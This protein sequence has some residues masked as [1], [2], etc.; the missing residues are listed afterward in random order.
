MN[1]PSPELTQ[2]IVANAQ[3]LLSQRFGGTQQLLE[4]KDLA[5][6][7]NAVV[8]R[9]KVAPSPFLQHKSVVLKYVPSA[10][11]VA[12]KASLIREIVAYQFTTSLNEEVRPGPV[13]LAYDV[14]KKLLVIT[15]AGDGDTVAD[16]LTTKEDSTRLSLLRNLGR[17]LGKMHSGTASK[18]QDFHILLGRM[19]A[20]H[21]NI[22]R[23]HEYRERMI[24]LAI[25][26]GQRLVA[27]AGITI[28]D[29]VHN[30]ATDASR[31]LV[32]GQHRAF[33]P[34]DLSPDNIL[35]A[36]HR[37]HFLDYEWAGFRDATFDVA[38]VIAGFPQF[39]GTQPISDQ[40]A[41]AFIDSWVHEVSKI[42]PNVNNRE[43]LHARIVTALVGWSFSSVALMHFGVDEE[44]FSTLD[45]ERFDSEEFIAELVETSAPWAIELLS[46]NPLSSANPL[47]GVATGSSN[48]MAGAIRSGENFDSSD[49][50]GA[51]DPV[52]DLRLI[53]RDLFET[54][55]ALHRFASRGKDA[56]F[57]AVAEFA[58][59]VVERLS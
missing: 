18:E 1:N 48:T 53:R 59:D 56:R 47:S 50:M 24:Q 11:N 12:E 15:D 8:M 36:D 38:C 25:P 46:G 37:T 54:F 10:D 5:G 16:L 58:H 28:P 9:V 32:S 7:G 19:L 23:F 41:D 45:L 44:T 27:A 30:F 17:A 52:E 13:L 35:V 55:E 2:E 34:F 49:E 20:R 26:C 43:R 6:S 57:P 14:E 21:P 22:K 39:L 29:D 42:W 3:A 4:A 51:I 40:E 33:T 31:R